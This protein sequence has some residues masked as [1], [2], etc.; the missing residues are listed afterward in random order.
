MRALYPGTFDPMHN[1]HVNIAE[2]AARLFDELVVAIY[3][4][5]PKN[6]L[7]DTEERVHLAQEA[8]QH[9]GNVKIVSF[10][11]L[12]IECA[13]E[14]GAQVIV[15]GLRNVADFE[16]EYQIGLANRHMAPDIELCCLISPTEYAY[17]SS[18]IVKEVA[19]LEG[20]VSGWV[21]PVIAQAMQAALA[22]RKGA[23]QP[24]VEKVVTKVHSKLTH[25]G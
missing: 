14:V 13:R 5:P 23:V 24:P 7:F 1:G 11:G 19:A 12:T 15:R 21:S 17:L 20:D 3:Q 6:L 8:L 10:H 2:R 9:L 22:R 16:F 4:A 25:H 18:T